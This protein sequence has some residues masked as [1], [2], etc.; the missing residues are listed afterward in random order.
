MRA[1]LVGDND[2]FA[3]IP[4]SPRPRRSTIHPSSLRISGQLARPALNR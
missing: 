2:R 3:D 4:D 1:S